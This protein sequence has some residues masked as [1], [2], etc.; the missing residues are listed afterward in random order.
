MGHV[1]LP[2]SSRNTLLRVAAVAL[3]IVTIAALCWPGNSVFARLRGEGPHMSAERTA[4]TATVLTS[5]QVL[6]IGG[7][8]AKGAIA[9]TISPAKP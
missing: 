3:A 5:G 1:G 8:R 6:I 4:H 9:R 7:E 2:S